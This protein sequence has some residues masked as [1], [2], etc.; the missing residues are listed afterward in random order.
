[1]IAKSYEELEVN[2]LVAPGWARD[3]CIERKA[4]LVRVDDDTAWIAA[5]HPEDIANVDDL[6]WLCKRRNVNVIQI[7]E[8]V[9]SES[10]KRLYDPA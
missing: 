4:F 3:I 8:A 5:V 9:L 6:S 7:S 2:R 1:M 10:I